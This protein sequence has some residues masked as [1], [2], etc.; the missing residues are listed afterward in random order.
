MT[1]I[2]ERIRARIDGEVLDPQQIADFLKFS[3]RKVVRLLKNGE[4]PG[5]KIGN[6]RRTLKVELDKY[7]V[8]EIPPDARA[9]E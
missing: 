2:S 7:L 1:E 8:T 6:Q 5:K 3:K 4:L 9:K